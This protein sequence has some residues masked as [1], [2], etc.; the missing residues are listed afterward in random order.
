[1]NLVKAIRG[2]VRGATRDQ[3]IYDIRTMEQFVHASLSRQRFLLVLFGIF[4]GLA[5][6]LA[7]IGIYGVLA[8][9]TSQRV[10]EIGVRMALGASAS[11]VMRMVFRQSLGMIFLGGA[12]GIAASLAA[13]HVLKTQV[14][15]M[16]Q[17]D[18]LTYGVMISI[19][20]AAALFA[21]FIPARRASRIDPVKA[22]R[23]E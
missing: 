1:L 17:T 15:G 23:Q 11:D 12:I 13:A 16:R 22:L 21:S 5:L 18:F 19:L 9:L 2:E 10:P 14:A 3:A 6:L 7:S 8:Y 4:A 20:A